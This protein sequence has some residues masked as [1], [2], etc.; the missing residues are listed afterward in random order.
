VISILFGLLFL[1]NVW[2]STLALPG[3][4]GILALIGGAIAI[5]G[6]FRVK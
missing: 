6:A 3:A 4:I 1:F 5:V 2:G